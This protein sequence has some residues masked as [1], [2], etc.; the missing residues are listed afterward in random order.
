MIQR[1]AR[2]TGPTR[3][4][5]TPLVLAAT[6]LAGALLLPAV[7][8]S[9]DDTPPEV[10]ALSNPVTLEEDE[11]RYYTRQFKGKCAR[12]H[13]KDGT[14]KGDSAGDQKVPPANF[15]DAA[16][17]TSRSDGQLYYQILAGGGEACAMPAFGPGTDHSWSEDKI[18]HMV[19]YVRRFAATK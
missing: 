4:L 7:G 3:P 11:V 5:R 6:A 14:G 2:T 15:T 10:A 13:S 12:C 1:P 16:Y 18:W 9:R 19:A 17:M 8:W